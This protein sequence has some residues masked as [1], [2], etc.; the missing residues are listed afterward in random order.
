MINRRFGFVSLFAMGLLSFGLGGCSTADGQSED[1]DALGEAT[2]AIIGGSPASDYQE[3]ALVN[4]LRGGKR[5]AA[6]SGSIIAPNVVL[7][8]GHCVHGFDGWEIVAPFANNQTAMASK[9]VTKDW[10][11]DKETVDPNM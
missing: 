4:M 2:S 10:T 11:T 8:A 9:A 6:C 5:A 1:R 7:T 3:A